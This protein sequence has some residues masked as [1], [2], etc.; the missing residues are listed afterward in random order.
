[1]RRLLR[2]GGIA[3]VC[4]GA[5]CAGAQPHEGELAIKKFQPA[6]GLKVELFAAEPLL[7]NPVAF[8]I[9]EKGR[10]F[11]SETH[12]YREAIFDITKNLPW[13]IDDLS[14][15]TVED[16]A[17]FLARTFTTNFNILTKDS[18][19]VRLVEDSNGDGRAEM[20][21]VFAEGFRDSVSGTAAGVLA[22]H[23]QVW[24]T[25]IPDVWRF[26]DANGDGKFERRARLRTG[27]GVRIGVSGH[28]LH[29]LAM[30]PDGKIYF[31]IGDRASSPSGAYR[32]R[33]FSSDFLRRV[34]PDTG[35]VFR[36]NPDGTDLEVFAIGLRNPQELAF[37]EFGNLWTDDNDTAGKDDSRVIHV[38]EGA[39]YGWRV[40]Y[41]HLPNF[42]PWVE[43]ELWK[44]GLDD[45][46][47]LAGV[48]AQGPSGLAYNPGTCLGEKYRGK[49]LVCDFPGGVWSFGV[50][51]KGASYEVVEKEKFLW[52]LWPTDVD[53]GLDGNAYVADWVEGWSPTGKGR[54]YRISDPAQTDKEAAGEVAKLM[55]EGFTKRSIEELTRLLGH[56]DLRIRTEAAFAL[57]Q[58]KQPGQ[59]ALRA[60][61]KSAP[62]R[63][64][65]LHA[66]WG[67]ALLDANALTANDWLRP[68][69][70][71]KDEEVRAQAAKVAGDL[72]CSVVIKDLERLL[73]DP[74]PRV[75]Y[76]AATSIGKLRHRESAPLVLNLLR[77]NANRDPY[78]V[79]AGV[80]A[81]L[82]IGNLDIVVKAAQDK[83]LAVRRTALLCL[84][85]L[86]RIEITQFLADANP[87]FA[88]EAARA[89][90]DAPIASAMSRLAESLERF[91][92]L[93]VST[94]ASRPW[95]EQALLRSINAN[96]RAGSY[97]AALRVAR[98][99]ANTNAPAAARVFALDALA[100]WPKPGPLD[101][102]VGLWRPLPERPAYIA[103]DAIHRFVPALLNDTNEP[104][105]LAALR[106]VGKLGLLD[107]APRLLQVFQNPQTPN[108][109]RR[110]TMEALAALPDA[111]LADVV[112]V[113]LASEDIQMRR[114]AVRLIGRANLPD[115]AAG[116]DKLLQT[117]KDLRLSQAA[118][119]ALGELREPAADEV[120]KHHLEQLQAGKIRPELRLDLLDAARK[121]AA[122]VVKQLVAAYE[123]AKSQSDPLAHYREALAGGDAAT[124]RKI[125]FER[126]DVECLRCHQIRGNGGIV[127]PAL[128]GIGKKQAREYLLESIV[129]PN[130]HIA[131]G[132]ENVT[133]VM[134]SGTSYAGVL[135]QE[136]EQ[137][138][139][140]E[141][142]EDGRLTLKK[143]DIAS[144]QRGLSAM[145]E[146][147]GAALSKRD[148]R[149]LVEYLASL[150]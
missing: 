127:G 103:R 15:R 26:T 12:R 128:D 107:M 105:A 96:F 104:V 109:I 66:L 133:L 112:K 150:K 57:H 7:E 35:A 73:S 10:F 44:G 94:S 87:R 80:M 146:T 102:V 82:G 33:G 124:G 3:G 134:K 95:N 27:F 59:A 130:K 136:T 135:K 86:E 93:A 119:T 36:C 38:V 2:F 74:S 138:V 99:A 60:A 84:R 17:I 25:C 85:R 45:A 64:A 28:D 65:K 117:E 121:R 29:G 46:L 126:A 108:T 132:F 90:N 47:P 49:F 88:A 11:I 1:M 78:L 147:I 81:L 148:L 89:I 56:A 113:A 18:E 114:D 53:F 129:F 143:G 4:L 8:S 125:F 40:S 91:T 122:P 72:M 131:P 123:S 140:I 142:G 61:L 34:L 115:V 116:L 51:P 79:H 68:L 32:G 52:N 145:P 20:S 58:M 62:S 77:D 70:N 41:Q 137:E 118:Y 14:F 21:R 141:S 13:L 71:D 100:D 16:R 101:R 19:L 111:R 23:G 92:T 139:V 5:W 106:C 39:D 50:K 69:L 55:M 24:F 9:D 30:G 83:D 63:H 42:G 144:R 6:S 31:S 22:R 76:Y 120:L 75:R 97:T 110:A 149:D 54:L 37:D 48:V 67:V 43:E 98:L